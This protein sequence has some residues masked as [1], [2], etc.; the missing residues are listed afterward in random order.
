MKKNKGKKH[1][2]K[3]LWDHFLRR[4]LCFAVCSYGDA[5]VCVG[6]VPFG[7]YMHIVRPRAKCRSRFDRVLRASHRLHNKSKKIR[8]SSLERLPLKAELILAGWTVSCRTWR[9][10]GL[11]WLSSMPVIRYLARVQAGLST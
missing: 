1:K 7:C 10:L 6:G 8:G 5:F 3:A 2:K 4:I 9:P 11:D